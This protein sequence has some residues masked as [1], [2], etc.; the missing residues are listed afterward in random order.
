MKRLS[1]YTAK[2][3]KEKNEFAARAAAAG[4]VITRDGGFCEKR[5]MFY[6]K[7]TC[8]DERSVNLELTALLMD[9]AEAENAVYRYS[10]KMRGAA[11]KIRQ[12]PVFQQEAALLKIFLAENKFLF[13]EGYTTFRLNEYREN[14]DMMI[15][16]MIKKLK[17]GN[18]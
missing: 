7:F 12:T 17:H 4:I 5:Q 1:I 9:I 14:L 3:E 10:P 18:K 16:T 6:T 15:Y 2:Y 13:L 8:L 11:A